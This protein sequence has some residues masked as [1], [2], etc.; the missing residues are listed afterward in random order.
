MLD[1]LDMLDND[2]L[3][4]PD[5]LNMSDILNMI[6]MFD[7]PNFLCSSALDKSLKSSSDTGSCW[8]PSLTGWADPYSPSPTPFPRRPFPPIAPILTLENTPSENTLNRNYTFGNTVSES[9]FSKHTFGT[10]IFQ[11]TIEQFAFGKYTLIP[12]LQLVVKGVHTVQSLHSV[13]CTPDE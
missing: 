8:T 1:I 4:M 2:I 9:K 12:S 7:I 5:V 13:H 10:H 11:Y 3:N 6:V